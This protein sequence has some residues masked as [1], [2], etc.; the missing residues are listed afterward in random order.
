MGGFG[1]VF[2]V[3]RVARAAVWCIS[4]GAVRC[5]LPLC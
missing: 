5:V 2:F 4:E 3:V 1:S